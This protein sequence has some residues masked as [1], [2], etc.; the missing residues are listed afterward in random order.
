M[1]VQGRRRIGARAS[2]RCCFAGDVEQILQGDRNAGVAARFAPDAAQ[3]VHRV[4]HLACALG[5]HLDEGARAFAIRIGDTREALFHQRP[6]GGSAV[7][8][9]LGVFFQRAHALGS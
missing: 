5:V 6:T 2:R 8:Q 7:G 3:D 9:G 1:R 4:R